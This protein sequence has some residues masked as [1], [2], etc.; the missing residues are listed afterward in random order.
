MCRRSALECKDVCRS[1]HCALAG[2]DRTRQGDHT[3]NDY[4]WEPLTR[5]L[6][7]LFSK[8]QG[9][10]HFF[11]L[12]GLFLTILIW[13]PWRGIMACRHMHFS[14]TI[15]YFYE[16]AKLHDAGITYIPPKRV[17]VTYF[18]GNLYTPISKSPTAQGF[19]A[20]AN[21]FY[22]AKLRDSGLIFAHAFSL[23]WC[24]IVRALPVLLSFFMFFGA[25]LDN[26]SPC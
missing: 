8:F 11:W 3:R 5:K 9:F 1:V 15:V 6:F 18:G 12:F 25:L 2:L 19:F 22:G 26:C 17:R 4:F 16:V 7:G 14:R 20:F 21:P 23:L 24:F 13:S 10:Q